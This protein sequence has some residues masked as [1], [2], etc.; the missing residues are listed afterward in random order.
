MT[1]YDVYIP[2]TGFIKLEVQAENEDE[3]INKALKKEVTTDDI[4]EWETHNH[5]VKGNVFYG[6]LKEIE[7]LEV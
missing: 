1:T 5:V 6:K 2:I 7:V 3:A 4:E